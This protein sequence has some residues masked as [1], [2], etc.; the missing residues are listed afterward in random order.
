MKIGK[1]SE[2]VLKRSVL[3]QIKNRREEVLV[4]AGIGEDCAILS[5]QEDEVVTLTV[6]PVTATTFENG[7]YGIY[8]AVN[9]IAA[10]GAEPV[11]VLVSILLPESTYES[12]LKEMMQ[13][14]EKICDS[15]HIQIIGGHTEV[16]RAVNCPIITITGVGKAGKDTYASTRG[17]KPGQDIVISKWIGLEGTSIIAHEKEEELREKYPS[18][19]IHAAKECRNLLSVIPEAA[20][21]IKSGVRTMH[22]VTEGGVFGALWELAE[23]SGVGLEIDLQKLPIRQETIEVCEFVDVN[24]YQ[25]ISSGCLLMVTDQGFDLVRALEKNGINAAVIGKITDNNDR[26]VIN[27]E[28]RR[29]LEPPKSDDIYKLNG[30]ER[31]IEK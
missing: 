18:H 20:T 21:A 22:D 9:D 14:M 24:P 17:A 16:A 7:V 28:E 27:E 25:M 30:M 26:V 1:V 29:F 2:S 12:E 10:T 15:L 13:E 23:S 5:F 11:G 4:G 3:K 31:K 6:D 19:L 8:A